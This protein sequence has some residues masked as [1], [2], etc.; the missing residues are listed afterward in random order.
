MTKNIQIKA[1]GKT[2]SVG[3]LKEFSQKVRTAGFI[4]KLKSTRYEERK[5]SYFK[6]KSEALRKIEKN[7][8]RQ[9]AYKLGKK[10]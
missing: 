6:R 1:K 4:N 9:R 10:I 2:N 8:K 7:E 5:P 3:L